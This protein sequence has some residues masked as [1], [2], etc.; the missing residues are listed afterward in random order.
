[1]TSIERWLAVLFD[2]S[3]MDWIGLTFGFFNQFTHCIMLLFKLTTLDEIGWDLAEVKKRANLTDILERVAERAESTPRLLGIVDN[4]GSR[5]SAFLFK[6][7]QLI[8]AIKGTL[9]SQMT[10]ATAL[11]ME[12]QQDI[13]AT[14]SAIPGGSS[15]SDDID[16]SFMDDPW[17]TDIFI[18]F[19][20]F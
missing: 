9:M 15:I 13:N 20:Q 5:E 16:M 11:Q 6:S 8:Q 7:T 2:V 4:V 18:P 1:L 12:V 10:P 19:W 14:I 17:A 3:V